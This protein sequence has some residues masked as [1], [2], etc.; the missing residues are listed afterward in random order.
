MQVNPVVRVLGNIIIPY[1]FSPDRITAL[2]SDFNRNCFYALTSNHTIV[3]YKSNGDR[4][5]QNVQT[6]SNLYKAAQ[7]KAP[8]CPALTPQTWSILSLHVIEPGRTQNGPHLMAITGNGL[9]LYFAPGVAGYSYGYSL[10]GGS[11]S[12]QSQ[13]PLQLIHVRLPPSNLLHPDE[14]ST[15][16]TNPVAGYGAPPPQPEQAARSFVVKGLESVTYD[17]GLTIAAQAGDVDGADYI[18]CL[19]PDLTRIGSLGQVSAVPS[20]QQQ[21][22]PYQN[23]YGATTGPSRPT[24]TEYATALSIPGRTWGM[25]PVPRPVLA[26]ASISPPDSPS[27]AI[28]NELASQFSEPSRQFMIL[29][30]AGLTFLAKRRALDYLRAVIEEF[31]VEGNPEPLIQFRDR[32]ESQ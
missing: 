26:A 22:T 8:G 3:V 15:P 17:A 20:Q 10:G 4:A 9:R 24:L 32:Y 11:S 31:Q 5:I 29:T 21:P 16:Y 6:L 27:Y 12:G 23:A 18:L 7:E 14:Q 2:A 28:T 19:S 1:S 25:A 30:N 13:R